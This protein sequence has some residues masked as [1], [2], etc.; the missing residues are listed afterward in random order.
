MWR[1]QVT[2]R[3]LLPFIALRHS[4]V[5][6]PFYKLVSGHWGRRF[7]GSTVGSNRAEIKLSVL[8][9]ACP[10]A[11]GDLDSHMRLIL[12]GSWQETGR[13]AQKPENGLESREAQFPQL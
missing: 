1:T 8:C 2:T 10:V 11:C 4:G 13:K 3:G 7:Q 6:C 12:V 9:L 5:I